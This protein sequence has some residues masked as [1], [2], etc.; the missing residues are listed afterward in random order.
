[1]FQAMFAH[2]LASKF[3]D[4][5]VSGVEIPELG[6]LAGSD[7]FRPTN[8][9]RISG[10]KIDVK[11]I[12][13]R[14]GQGKID[15]I[16]TEALGMRLEYY[17][18]DIDKYRRMFALERFKKSHCFGS[19]HLV[20]NVR[21]AEIMGGIHRDYIPL[22]I[23]FY[24]YVVSETLLQPVFMGQIDAGAPYGRELL[25][26][27]PRAFYLGNKSPVEDFACLL[28]ATN[29]CMSISSFSWLASWFSNAQN[30]HMPAYGLFNP[31]QRP[32]INLLPVD[33]RRYH[34]Y[35]FPEV[36]WQ[37][38]ANQMDGL[39]RSEI[40]FARA[41]RSAIRSL[42]DSHNEATQ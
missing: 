18:N 25:R 15:C 27:F 1:M 4:C 2:Y 13:R 34:F 20:V 38:T 22:P 5:V 32:D 29:I 28:N 7:S 35:K 11:E 37:G 10:H 17:R 41:N 23:D 6:I 3:G 39:Y 42:V 19:D 14:T 12:L 26:R 8:Q 24:D 40:P 9:L 30:I 33:D 31:A 36:K 21:G 16:V